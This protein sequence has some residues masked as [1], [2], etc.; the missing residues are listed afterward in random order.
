[1]TDNVKL[2]KYLPT[3]EDLKVWPLKYYIRSDGKYCYILNHGAIM[4]GCSNDDS[5]IVSK[6]LA[7]YWA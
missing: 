4:V 3:A 5:Y 1:M 6:N 2:K 7:T